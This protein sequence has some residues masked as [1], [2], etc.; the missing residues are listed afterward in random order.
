MSFSKTKDLIGQLS[1][2]ER[3]VSEFSFDELSTEDA[4]ILK[5]SFNSFKN[6]L[7]NHIYKSNTTN[8]VEVKKSENEDVECKL[9]KQNQFIAHVSHEIRTPLNSIIGFA[10]LLNEEKLSKSQH[11]KVDAIQFASTSLLKIINEVLEYSKL[12]SGNSNFETIDFNLSGL[13]NDVMFLCQTLMLDQK[14]KMIIDI[15]QNVPKI[16]KGDPTK[17]SQVLLN[18]LGNSIKFVDKGFIKLRVAAK[19][20]TKND[21]VLEFSVIDTGIGISIEKL[22]KIFNC[23]AQ[24]TEDTSKKYGGT[25]LGLS[26]TKEIIEKQNGN[27]KITSEVGLGTTINFSIPYG[28]GSIENIPIQR[29]DS[30]TFERGKELLAGTEI[31]V[32]EDNLMNQH[33]IKE[34]LSKWDC[35]VY[36]HVNL[37]K[38]LAVLASKKIDLILMD[39]KMPNLNGFEISKTLRSHE[40][41]RISQVPIVAFSADFT[42]QDSNECKAIGI[43]DFLLKPYTL[44]E[45]MS[46]I[47]NNKRTREKNMEFKQILQKQMIEP[48]ETSKVDLNN[49]LKDCFGEL[50]M[51]NE[52]VKLFKMNALEFIGNVKVHLQTENL[53]EI[54]L[55]AHKLKAGFAMLKANGMHQLIVELESKCK[56]NKLADVIELYELFL[57]DYPRLEQNIDDNL[58][59]LNKK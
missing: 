5:T 32:F 37:Q 50:E 11:K 35:K 39:L 4:K 28:L 12:S 6:S 55:C 57:K 20:A 17:L 24:A 2:L 54:A 49:L 51:L 40:D 59:L 44:N 16:I 43:N 42:E 3:T 45:L 21:C 18:L 9:L 56:E 52:L 19:N 58:T 8:V 31:L 48:K 27:I 10:N 7:E 26:I 23:Y 36:T 34:Q 30:K 1:S 15:D 47:L 46:V 38:G 33:L 41:T 25:G 14:V 22:D 29:I 13:L 53:K